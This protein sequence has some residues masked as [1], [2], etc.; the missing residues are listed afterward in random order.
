M[1]GAQPNVRKVGRWKPNSGAVK[2]GKSFGFKVESHYSYLGWIVSTDFSEAANA[3]EQVFVA[4][5]RMLLEVHSPRNAASILGLEPLFLV[6]QI[7]I[8]GRLACWSH[9]SAGLSTAEKQHGI[10][11]FDCALDTTLNVRSDNARKALVQLV[12]K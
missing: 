2:I 5:S 3:I 9:I 11:I 4:I 10:G 12:R 8:R 6:G 7:I 1:S